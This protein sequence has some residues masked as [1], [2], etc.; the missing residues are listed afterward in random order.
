MNGGLV[1][2]GCGIV[3]NGGDV[4]DKTPMVMEN[5]DCART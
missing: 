5:G 3:V 1:A 4:M 2:L